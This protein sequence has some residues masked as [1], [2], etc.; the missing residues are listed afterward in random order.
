[1]SEAAISTPPSKYSITND[2]AS[3]IKTTADGFSSRT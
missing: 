1:M 2:S 3:S